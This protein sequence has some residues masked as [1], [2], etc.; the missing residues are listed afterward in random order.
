MSAKRAVT[1]LFITWT[2]RPSV[3]LS[4]SS[5]SHHCRLFDVALLPCNSDVGLGPGE[6]PCPLSR[7][8]DFGEHSC[9]Q[10][11]PNRSRYQSSVV[12]PSRDHVPSLTRTMLHSSGI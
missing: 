8:C 12:E 4:R 11:K 3:F 2:I 7:H 6:D 9:R 5:N 10:S 1:L